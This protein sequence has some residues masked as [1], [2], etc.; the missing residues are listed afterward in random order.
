M[1]QSS[2]YLSASLNGWRV[3]S[4]GIATSESDGH[5]PA[6]AI[7]S[8][9]GL[10]ARSVQRFLEEVLAKQKNKRC[11]IVIGVPASWCLCATIPADGLPKGNAAQRDQAMAFRLESVLPITAEDCAISF[12]SGGSGT[13]RLGIAIEASRLV[14]LVQALED[15]GH[16]VEAIVPRGLLTAQAYLD[17][18]APDNLP[19]PVGLVW[20]EGSGESKASDTQLLL[21]DPD[22]PPRWRVLNGQGESVSQ[23]LNLESETG[24]HTR[25]WLVSEAIHEAVTQAIQRQ[26]PDAVL[27]VMP[28]SDQAEQQAAR[29]LLEH[30]QKPWID[31]RCGPLAPRHQWRRLQT[32]AMSCIV[33]A[34]VVLMT[35]IA[36]LWLRA[37]QFNLLAQQHDQ[38]AHD[39]FAEAMPGQ[40]VPTS[41]QRRLNTR[42]KQLRGEQGLAAG[43]EA[44]VDQ[45]PTLVLLHEVLAGL[46]EGQRF[47]IT[48]LRL[49]DGELRLTGHARSHGEADQ[50]ANALR[51]RSSFIVEPP[52]TDSLSRNARQSNPSG[53][54]GA[55]FGG[56]G[57]RFLIQAKYRKP[58]GQDKPTDGPSSLAKREGEGRP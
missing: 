35:A 3:R 25:R 24:R 41:P 46:P 54:F 26:Q 5:G 23:Q 6:A 29:Y 17:S 42:L 4:A 14:E 30:H 45:V 33:A 13:K 7:D 44:L 48:D 2:F 36:L 21:V 47:A 1:G 32:P 9:D 43:D 12:V 15:D 56:G 51:T 27:D 34:A 57:V 39:A 58:A 55:T 10:D 38:T 37:D 18:A 53:G 40:P 22:Q 8:G 11:R 50:L 16:E 20:Q 19:E 52:S 28:L 31:L 49:E